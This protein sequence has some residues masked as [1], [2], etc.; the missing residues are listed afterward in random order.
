VGTE[1]T[2]LGERSNLNFYDEAGSIGPEF[3][4]RTEPF[5]TQSKDFKTGSGLNADILPKDI[6]N[7]LIYSS[8]AEDVNTVLF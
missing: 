7:Q 3:F 5:A 1:K 2:V 4:T 8:S 6:P